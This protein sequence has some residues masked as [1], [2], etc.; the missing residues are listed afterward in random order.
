[1]YQSHKAIYARLH[2][3]LSIKTDTFLYMFSKLQIRYQVKIL[4]SI[5]K[6]LAFDGSVSQMCNET[7]V[8]KVMLN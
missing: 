6:L 7:L 1:M 4:C 2:I 3:Y 5:D 8:V